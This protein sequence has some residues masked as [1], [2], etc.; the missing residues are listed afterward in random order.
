ME[1]RSTV[2]PIAATITDASGCHRH[3][4]PFA[5]VAENALIVAAIAIDFYRQALLT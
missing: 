4:A 2:Q 5:V 1:R 3:G